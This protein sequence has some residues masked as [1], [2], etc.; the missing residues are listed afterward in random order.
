MRTAPAL[1]A[2]VGG[3]NYFIIY[4]NNTSDTCDTISIAR[5]SQDSTALDITGNVSG[6]QGH[7]GVVAT[8]NAA[9]SVAFDAEL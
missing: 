4:A 1:S 6:T 2:A 8:N 5:A 7:G 9:A 3:T